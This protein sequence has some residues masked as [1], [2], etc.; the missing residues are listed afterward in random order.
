MV[1]PPHQRYEFK[2]FLGSSHYWALGHATKLPSTSRVLDIGSGSGAIGRTLK[3]RGFTDLSAV[4]IDPQAREHVRDVY[5]RIEPSVDPFRGER[6]DLILLL[7]V[8]EHLSDPFTVFREVSEML[9]PGG[10][11]LL[12]VPNVAHWSVRFP[13]LFGFFEYAERGIMDKTHLQFFTRRRVNR[14]VRS[15]TALK[16]Q[17]QNCSIEPLE[18]VLPKWAWN[19]SAFSAAARMRM[20]LAR[21]LP[22]LMAYQH[23]ARVT[24]AQ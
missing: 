23:L 6:F 9:S 18:L 21:A 8:L 5:R 7:D 19:N 20:A 22:G 10:T 2:P 16:V 17:E 24:R 11:L 1:L 3:D 13:L 15:V 4:E 14:L 12:S